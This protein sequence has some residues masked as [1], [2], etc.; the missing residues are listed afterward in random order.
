MVVVRLGYRLLLIGLLFTTTCRLLVSESAEIDSALL[1]T[2]TLESRIINSTIGPQ[3]FN[4][5]QLQGRLYITSSEFHFQTIFNG[6]S[7]L[8]GGPAY[9]LL[10]EFHIQFYGDVW[11]T[12]TVRD[13]LLVLNYLQVSP[14][15]GLEIQ[16]EYWSKQ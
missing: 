5:P 4:P 10:G 12:Y 6:T 7:R 2:Y 8:Y 16:R 11:G 13:G 15:W 1:G 14:Q 9:A 3:V